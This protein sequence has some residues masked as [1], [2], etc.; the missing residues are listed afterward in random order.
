VGLFDLN[1]DPR[2]VGQAYRHL[3]QLFDEEL[4]QDPTINGVLK[5]AG[6]TTFEEATKRH[7]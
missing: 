3:I 6:Q 1:R 2:P 5:D 7:A 4:A